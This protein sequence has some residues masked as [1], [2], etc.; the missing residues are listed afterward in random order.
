MGAQGGASGGST[1]G[2][3]IPILT[4]PEHHWPAPSPGLH[5]LLHSTIWGFLPSSRAHP[6]SGSC[7][8]CLRDAPGPS[9]LKKPFRAASPPPE[10]GKTDGLGANFPRSRWGGKGWGRGDNGMCQGWAD[11][12]ALPAPLGSHRVLGTVFLPSFT[13]WESCRVAAQGEI[14]QL[15]FPPSG[16]PPKGSEEQLGIIDGGIWGFFFSSPVND[17]QID[18]SHYLAR[19][20]SDPSDELFGIFGV[21]WC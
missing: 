19:E 15:H 6:W 1:A 9:S 2:K 4:P 16:F 8:A 3:S 20:M 10:R 14:P 11:A 21:S 18:I 7:P 12:A 13:T 5:F 17:S